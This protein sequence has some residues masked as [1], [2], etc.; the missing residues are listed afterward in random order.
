MIS[1]HSDD[2]KLHK[3][4][5]FIEISTSHYG[6]DMEVIKMKRNLIWMVIGV[7]G[8]AIFILMG[9]S[10]AAEEKEITVIGVIEKSNRMDYVVTDN[11]KYRIIGQDFS[12]LMGKKLKV[13]GKISESY[14]GKTLLVTYME[15]VRN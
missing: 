12:K 14:S 4:S 2:S 13:T 5:L 6:N 11:E 9:V 7:F 15:I 10:P 3:I 1:D 8:I